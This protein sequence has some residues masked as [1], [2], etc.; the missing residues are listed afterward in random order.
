MKQ[1]WEKL[2][3][4]IDALT[5][6][7]RAMVFA[8]AAAAII[9]LVYSMLLSPLYA[10]QKLLLGS[11]SQQQNEISGIDAAITAKLQAYALDPDAPNRKRL[12]TLKAE[13]EHTSDS[14]RAVQ[15]GLVA[16]EK[17]IPV[18]GQLLRA[19]ENL[20]LLSLRNLPV[21]GVS[22][23]ALKSGQD[24]TA[25]PIV[26]APAPAAASA[27]SAAGSAGSA[28]VPSQ[29][30]LLYRHGVEIVLQG[31]YLDMINYMSTLEASPTQLFWGKARLDAT[32]Y[33]HA[34][35]TLTLYTLSLDEQW[36]KL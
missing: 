16:P 30:E 21:T 13:A 33:P 22:G 36:M 2:A 4:K 5:L 31:G 9:F 15:K 27:G 29:P 1:Q 24:G 23:R 3:L 11:I 18:V 14:L 32:Q 12:E 20:R 8:A 25:A 19:N 34:T 10:K 35:L 6:R 17:M 26:K 28:E 7:E